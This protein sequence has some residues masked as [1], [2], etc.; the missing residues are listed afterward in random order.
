MVL[1]MAGGNS[2]DQL[3]ETLRPFGRMVVVGIATR[4]RMSSRTQQTAEEQPQCYR[5]LADAPAGPP[6]L[7]RDSIDRV[8]GATAQGRSEGSGRR[9]L[10]G[11]SEVRRVHQD[12]AGRKTVGKLLDPTR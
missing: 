2:A 5:L 8:F 6:D 7:A 4:G 12:I 3:I 1:E 11:L 10:P 9:N